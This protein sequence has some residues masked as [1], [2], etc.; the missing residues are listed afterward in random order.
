MAAKPL[1]DAQCKEAVRLLEQHGTQVAAA[2]AGNIP[3][4]T[5][6]NRLREAKRR[7]FVPKLPPKPVPYK[8][9]GD[10][11]DRE[12]IRLRD[13]KAR[14][15][16]E[17]KAAHR[18][19][20]DDEAVREMLGTL[21]AKPAQPPEWLLRVPARRAGGATSEV[22]VVM[23]GC[24]HRGEVV[25]RAETNGVNEYNSQIMEE[26]ARRVVERVINLAAEHGPGNYPGIVVNVLGD[27]V[28]GGLHPELQKTDD[29]PPIVSA[30]RTRDILVWALTR[31]ADVFGQVY[32][33]ATCG[34]HGRMTLK[35]EFKEYAYKNAD[36][37]IYQMLLRHFA[38]TKDD[39]VKLDV[40]PS[41]EVFY[42]VYGKRFLAMHGDMLGVKGGDG[43][44]GSLGP[45]A[46]GEVKTRG[47]SASS[48]M[49]Y[50][51]LLIAHWHQALWLPRVTV[52]NTLKGWD[53]YAKNSLRATP[54]APSQSLFFVHPLC[55]ITSRW[56]VYAEKQDKPK[57]AEWV[58][59][60]D[61]G[62]A[63]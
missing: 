35:P 50:D 54:T 52:V 22:P 10:P 46:R 13:E 41:N 11:K 51:H 21:G 4:A 34:N 15:E 43:I 18:K 37:L 19:T 28:S 29:E 49:E 39:R 24:W 12:I 20:L 9:G 1:S 7:G 27:M 58:S 45:I 14:L 44:I 23:F 62:K 32:V 2:L 47:S 25:S 53:E 17:L 30:L 57:A 16:A 31:L 59:V 8:I 63:A 42:R 3:R 48:G 26:R 55:G 36:W 33:P 40:R 56:E 60:F 6:E 5:F 61:P 38:D